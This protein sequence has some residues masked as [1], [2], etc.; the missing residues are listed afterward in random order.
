MSTGLTEEQYDEITKRI[1]SLIVSEKGRIVVVKPKIVV[2]VGYQEIQQSPTYSSKYA[3]RFPRMLRLRED[4]DV[5]DADDIKRLEKIYK[6]QF[7]K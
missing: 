1:K 5:E 4:K 6:Q 7:K 2:E 3:L